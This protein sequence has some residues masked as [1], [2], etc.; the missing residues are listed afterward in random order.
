MWNGQSWLHHVLPRIFSLL[1]AWSR[2]LIRNP[3]ECRTLH[4]Y[5]VTVKC[6]APFSP[7]L[8]LGDSGSSVTGEAVELSSRTRCN[9]QDKAVKSCPARMLV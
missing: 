7:M 3:E 2:T 1:A 4:W 9:F 6:S 8:E 5:K